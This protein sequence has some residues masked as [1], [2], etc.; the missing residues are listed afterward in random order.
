MGDCWMVFDA[1]MV[2]DVAATLG[3][4]AIAALGGV[5]GTTLGDVRL[6]GGALGWPAMMVVSC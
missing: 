4:P 5:A 3:G 1:V 6:G 2:L